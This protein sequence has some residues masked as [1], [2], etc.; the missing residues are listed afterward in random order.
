MI[1]A[2]SDLHLSL[3]CDKP[4]D[5]F[6]V[7]W[8]NYVC[9][10][11]ENWQN[12]VGVEDTVVIP[13]DISWA[14][15][16]EDA[17]ADFSFIDKLN[18]KKIISKR[19]HDYFWETASKMK[20]FFDANEIKTI[21]ILHNNSFDIDGVLICGSKGYNVD[22]GESAEHNRKIL[23]RECVRLKISLDDAKAKSD[24]QPTVF[25]HYPPVGETFEID[26]ITSLLKN[27]VLR[28][29]ITDTS[30]EKPS[31]ML[32]KEKKTG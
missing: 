15:K 28:S 2:I 21:D 10:I 14:M 26:E 1:F 6:G 25:L 32:L 12:I 19:N 11:R 17:L 13:G 16:L 4:M 5:V 9:R 24:T 31:K 18:G 29:V 22:D 27:T 7:D 20:R 3:A 30:T 23:A 8:H